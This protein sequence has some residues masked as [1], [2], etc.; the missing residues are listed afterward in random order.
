M[1]AFLRLEKLRVR[2]AP[3]AAPSRVAAA[4]GA[5]VAAPA[6]DGRDPWFDYESW[7]V[8]TAGGEGQ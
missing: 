5:L 2:D 4:I 8:E 3:A 1:L 7:A 6:L